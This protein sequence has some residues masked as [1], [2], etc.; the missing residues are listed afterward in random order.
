MPS[1]KSI[2]VVVPI[3]QSSQV[4]PTLL[5]RLT[6]T[7]ENLQ[8]TFEIILV[9]DCG[10]DNSWDTIKNAARSDS[11]IIGIKLSRNYGQHNALL[12]GIRAANKD[13]VVTIDDDLQNPPEEIGILLDKLDEGYD[14]VYGSPQQQQHGF[15]RNQASRITKIAMDKV[16]DAHT[17]RH[18]SSFRVF[19]TN[20]RDAFSTYR[21]PFVNVDVLLTWG[22]TRFTVLKVK[23]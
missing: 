1:S 8:R 15:I 23:H 6:I 2:S 3:Y 13:I 19:H 7:L 16:I 12:C 17:A 11:R 9:E 14:V 21:S 10:S 5:D 20:I 22:A 18:I 4:L